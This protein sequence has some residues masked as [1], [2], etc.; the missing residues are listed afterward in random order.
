MLTESQYIPVIHP[1]EHYMSVILRWEGVHNSFPLFKGNK[2]NKNIPLSKYLKVSFIKKL[3][4]VL[5][6][7]LDLNWFLLRSTQF[8][9]YNYY[10]APL[11]NE[12]EFCAS[13]KKDSRILHIT[14]LQLRWCKMCA[15]ND[16]SDYGYFFWRNSHQ[17][18]RLIRC[19]RHK[20][21]FNSCCQFCKTKTAD[22]KQLK[23][24][25]SLER[26]LICNDL[27][28]PTVKINILTPFENWLEE[29]H[30]L[31]NKGVHVD[32]L[33]LIDRVNQVI[34]TKDSFHRNNIPNTRRAEAQKHLINE[35][36]EAGAYKLFTFGK[37]TYD[38]IRYY[39]AL[40]LGYILNK[41]TCHSPVMYALLGWAFLS[42][43][44]R[45]ELFGSFKKWGK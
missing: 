21:I 39:P 6:A 1:D 20:L 36:N 15:K 40:T 45:D 28:P 2:F 34:N 27:L 35:Y 29:L 12:K 41:S 33:A 16:I 38:S 3:V 30:H 44:E 26:C 11:D 9:H 8:A 24:F 31:S 18:P 10:E 23:A 42:D 14:D 19:P 32:K 4:S 13:I 25:K 43:E 5:P 17:D 37:V 7:D 22:Y